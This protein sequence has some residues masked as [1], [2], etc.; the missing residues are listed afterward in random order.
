MI[1]PSDAFFSNGPI[2]LDGFI[3]KRDGEVV[4]IQIHPGLNVDVKRKDCKAIDE[5]TDDLTGRSYVRV[6]LN[7]DAE[8][9]AVFQSRLAR[10]AIQSNNTPFSLGG[11]LVPLMERQGA[12]VGQGGV[13]GTGGVFGAGGTMCECETRSY[14][15]FW[16]ICIDDKKYTD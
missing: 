2:V 9:S 6:T 5:A 13:G 8:I 3:T 1:N 16:G 10:L 14:N 12:P 7:P 4:S 11:D 15:M